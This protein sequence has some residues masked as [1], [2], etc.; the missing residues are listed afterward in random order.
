V[1]PRHKRLLESN[2]LP[3]VSDQTFVKSVL[4]KTRA[5]LSKVDEEIAR[6]LNRLKKLQEESASLS[7]T[8]AQNFAVLSPLRRMP[9]EILCQI[10]SAT[11]PTALD[12]AS[13]RWN[14]GDSPWVLGQICS[15]WRAVSLSYPSLW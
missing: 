8:A 7:I 13:G 4:S 1:D 5:R 3:M 6:L 12:M 11:L 14:V 15:G 2:E 10:F 9:P